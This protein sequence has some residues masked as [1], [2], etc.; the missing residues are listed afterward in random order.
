MKPS[1]ENFKKAHKA[2][3]SA[4]SERNKAFE[5]EEALIALPPLKM[6]ENGEVR[7]DTPEETTKY[8]RKRFKEFV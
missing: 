7:Q 5:V 4:I 2:I 1:K 6:R 3:S 8:F